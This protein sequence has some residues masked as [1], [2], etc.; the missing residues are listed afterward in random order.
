[1]LEIKSRPLTWGGP[2]YGFLNQLLG[3]KQKYIWKKFGSCLQVL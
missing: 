3:I 2:Y 1:M